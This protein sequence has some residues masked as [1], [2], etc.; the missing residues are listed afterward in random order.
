MHHHHVQD[1]TRKTFLSRT[2]TAVTFW[3][4]A[5]PSSRRAK[6]QTVNHRWSRMISPLFHGRTLA[7]VNHARLVIIMTVI[8]M[9]ADNG[10]HKTDNRRDVARCGIA[11]FQRIALT[12]NGISFAP[13]VQFLRSPL[14]SC[15]R[16][17]RRIKKKRLR[18]IVSDMS[19]NKL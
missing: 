10:L 13:S 3:S 11:I 8:I 18:C 15:G 12:R 14:E 7:T 16:Q 4:F 17:T 19:T 1:C 2:V 6:R 5:R 9:T